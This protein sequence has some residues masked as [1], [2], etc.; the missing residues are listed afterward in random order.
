MTYFI[1][2]LFIGMAIAGNDIMAHEKMK[3]QWFKSKALESCFGEEVMKTQM[4]KMR[5]AVGKCNSTELNLPRYKSLQVV[6]VVSM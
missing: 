6:K 3:Q 4:E 1:F 5:E 2:L